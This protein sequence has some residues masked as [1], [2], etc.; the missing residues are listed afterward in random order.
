[1][2][3]IEASLDSGDGVVIGGGQTSNPDDVHHT[4]QRPMKTFPSGSNFLVR[5]FQQGFSEYVDQPGLVQNQGAVL[6]N[7]GDINYMRLFGTD[8][9]DWLT[10]PA[11]ST[12][13]WIMTAGDGDDFMQGTDNNI[14]LMLG[15][16]GDDYMHGSKSFSD[17]LIG[18]SGDDK[19]FGYGGDDKLKGGR[20]QDLMLGGDGNDRLYGG[21]GD[22]QLQGGDGDDLLLA[23]HGSN[24]YYGGAG[25]DR[26]GLM[27]RH[28]QNV[29]GDFDHSEGDQL[30]IRKR[31][32]DSVEVSFVGNVGANGEA[33]FWLE[34]SMGLTGIQAKAGTTVDDIMDS[35]KAI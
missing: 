19:L 20:G 21:K 26:F 6:R 18:G 28:E 9:N 12:A 34:S 1:M 13:K 17:D 32:L 29:I 10:A 24:M 27:K 31:H 2:Q 35:I 22:D 7:H 23:G 25:A 4:S 15:Q 33:Q 16:E 11:S 8:A 3:V 14:N 5:T 30:L